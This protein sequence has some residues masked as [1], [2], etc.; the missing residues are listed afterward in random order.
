[1]KGVI[2]AGGTGSRLFPLTKVTNKHLLPVGKYPMVVHPVMK[3]RQAGVSEI[4]VVTGRE[5][6]GDMVELLGSGA[7]FGVDFTYRVQDEAGGIA[8][9]LGLAEKF[10]A[11][12]HMCVILGDNVF[13]DPLK[14]HLDKFF[15]ETG[16]KGAMVLLKE[17]PDPHRF[18]V[19]EITVG[20]IAAIE[21][22]PKEPKT[23]LA[24]IGVYVFDS[25]V[26]EIV[27]TLKPSGRGELEITDVNSAYLKDQELFFGVLD[28]WWT[29]AGTFESYPRANQLAAEIS[30]DLPD[31]IP[32]P[33]PAPPASPGFIDP[34]RR[35][36]W[37]P[38]YM[39]YYPPPGAPAPAQAQPKFDDAGLPA[40]RP[41]TEEDIK[42]LRRKREREAGAI[43]M[44]KF[45]EPPKDPFPHDFDSEKSSKPGT[46]ADPA[47]ELAAMAAGMKDTAD[48][49]FAMGEEEERPSA[50]SIRPDLYKK[51]SEN[52]PDTELTT[53]LPDGTRSNTWVPEKFYEY[54]HFP[55]RVY[56]LTIDK[57][58]HKLA[59]ATQVD[60]AIRQI[61][62]VYRKYPENDER[63]IRIGY[64]FQWK[65]REFMLA[66]L[67]LGDSMP[68]VPHVYIWVKI[69]IWQDFEGLGT[70]V[71]KFR[72]D[73]EDA[74][75]IR[76]ESVDHIPAIIEAL[77]H[78]IELRQG[79]AQEKISKQIRDE[80]GEFGTGRKF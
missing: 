41:M 32:A 54:L 55:A 76:V 9:A 25:R 78:K 28:G 43:G 79:V 31:L 40:D 75:L 71:Q 39:G 20:R 50:E 3:L 65:D 69:D 10:A 63:M 7:A 29:D 48:L 1:M 6:M 14:P 68:P 27:K 19:A 70:A 30:W 15:A 66:S 4:L 59:L 74:R 37:P 18:G 64:Y 36:G 12:D 52:L 38:P 22:K 60:K 77:S 56:R 67:T 26:F 57:L 13:S 49:I 72:F 34:G 23:N 47:A 61:E 46:K 5:H 58:E 73:D 53:L 11:G 45:K 35:V 51:T 8:Q 21:E 33:M 80:S 2:L 17:V 16:G 62:N 42:L 24:V 44:P